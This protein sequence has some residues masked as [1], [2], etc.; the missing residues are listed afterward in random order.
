MGGTSS[1]PA[2][3]SDTP[4]ANSFKNTLYQYGHTF[5]RPKQKV[6]G[7]PPLRGLFTPSIYF[8]NYLINIRMSLTLLFFSSKHL[9]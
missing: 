3:G 8:N 9:R 2:K 5:Q 1:L 7:P 4:N 6:D